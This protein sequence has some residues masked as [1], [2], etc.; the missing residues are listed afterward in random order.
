MSW[1]SVPEAF[2][3][4]LRADGWS[5]DDITGKANPAHDA[6]DAWLLSLE[7]DDYRAEAEAHERYL[8]SQA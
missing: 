8:K 3:D 1:R 5:E 2:L 6:V 4:K 7:G